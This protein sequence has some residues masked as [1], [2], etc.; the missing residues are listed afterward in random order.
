MNGTEWIKPV[1]DRTSGDVLH[2]QDNPQEIS[3]GAY[4]YEDL[5]RIENNTRYVADDMLKRGITTEYITLNSKYNWS[6]K[7]IPTRTDMNRIINNVLL[8]QALSNPEILDD[9]ET[10]QTSSQMTWILANAIEKNLEIMLNQPLPEP[11]TYYLEIVNGTGSGY[12]TEDTVVDIVGVPYG[13]QA[14][15]MIFDRWVGDADDLQYVGDVYAQQTTFTMWHKDVKLEAQFKINI[16]RTFKI[17][18]GFINDGSGD[19]QRTFLP[20]D[21]FDIQ[22][23]VAPDDKVFYQWLFNDDSL[24]RY[25]TAPMASTTSVSMPDA[26]LTLTAFYIYPGVHYLNVIDGNGSGYYEY[27]DRP[28]ASQNPS[29]EKY[30]FSNWSYDTQYLDG[31][32][33]DPY[34]GVNMPDKNIRLKANYSYNYS[35]N[36]VTVINGSGGGENLREGSTIQIVGDQ[37]MEGEGFD[38]WSISGEGSL[39]WYSDIRDK[40]ADFVVGD[41]DAIIIA[42]Y[43]P[44]HNVSITNVNNTGNVST[45]QHVEGHQVSIGTEKYVGDYVFDHWE[46]NGNTISSSNPYRFIMSTSDRTFTAVYK[47]KTTFTLTVNNGTGSGEYE[48]G[49]AV[50]IRANDPAEDFVFYRWNYS[51]INGIVSRY[52]QQTSITMGDEDCSCTPE[53]KQLF[54]LTVINGT[55]TGT[56]RD[57]SWFSI[58]ANPAP[59]NYRFSHWQ[60][61]SGS[62]SLGNIYASHMYITIS[63]SDCT[64]EAIYEELPLYTLNVEGGSGSGQYRHGTRVQIV[65]DPAPD[66]Y[67]FLNWSGDVENEELSNVF[68]STSFVTSISKNMTVKAN[69]FI[70]EKV[71]Y[72][73]LT[74]NNGSGT[75]SHKGASEVTIRANS[76]PNGYKFWKW[77][78]DVSTVKD[79]YK[80]ETTLIM[81]LYPITVTATYI[82]EDATELFTL[83]V[84]YGKCEVPNNYNDETSWESTGD[85]ELGTQVN[86]KSDTPPNGF[87]FDR[88]SGDVGYVDNIESAETFITMAEKDDVEITATFIEMEKYELVVTDGYGTNSYYENTEVELV[89]NKVDNDN[90]HYEFL[91]WGGDIEYIDNPENNPAMLTMPAKDIAVYAVYNT[92]YNLNVVNGSG[93]GYYQEGTSIDIQANI[94]EEGMVFS[95]WTGD[96]SAVENI[97]LDKTKVNMPASAMRIIAQYKTENS[98]NSV[99][100]YLGVLTDETKIV[101]INEEIEMI[102]DKLEVG[103]IIIDNNGNIGICTEL[104]DTECTIKRVFTT[105]S[106]EV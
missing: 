90:E 18:N 58:D 91:S 55:G 8:L 94:P 78:G 64:L 85:F 83:T 62:V 2:A 73:Q 22:A 53:Y 86:I 65:A 27:G 103:S 45:T 63:G 41:G 67:R 30:I 28:Y 24:E 79:K 33:T 42:M 43:G 4:N 38:Y 104:N 72:Y 81:P 76:A 31:E 15:F 35:Y 54:D 96:V 102:S 105:N 47:L 39:A 75:G 36:T 95:R 74:V 49:S 25:V 88:W 17:I 100:K 48:Q 71:E 50:V 20:G 52:S 61:N 19:T 44:A 77:T 6:N 5:N 89:F 32:V 46:E 99:A 29:S 57:G 80:E 1:Y 37:A 92:Y 14:S 23:N 10:I 13:D 59:E 87:R 51:G 93:S 82:E 26:D 40:T 34:V 101:I 68:A 7:D 70:P 97:F 16:P 66:I 84:N 11:D 69:Y 12:Y 3:K 21:V 56:Y 106:K 60:V 98:E 9:L